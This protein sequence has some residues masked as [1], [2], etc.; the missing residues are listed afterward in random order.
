MSLMKRDPFDSP[1]PLR[2][3]MTRL[4]EESFISP[5]IEFL[6]RRT[7]PLD[8]YETDDHQTYVIEAALAGCKPEEL[9]VTAEDQ[10]L[11]IRVRK[12]S[13]DTEKKGTYV[14]R[15]LYT[16]EMMRSV[17]LPTAMN[18]QQIETTYEHGVLIVR[19][20]KAEEV[21]PKQIFVKVTQAV[22]AH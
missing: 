5:G 18:V 21:K 8:M 19:I 3:A 16:G 11:T 4:F 1:V 12:Q 10:T 7:F 2:K 15:E 6:S 22:G 17:T 9:Q 20:P 14:R 13:E